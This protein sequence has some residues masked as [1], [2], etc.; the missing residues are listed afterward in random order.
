MKASCELD[1]PVVPEPLSDD[2]AVVA[3][4]VVVVDDVVVEDDPWTV[5]ATLAVFPLVAPVATMW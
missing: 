5:I 1:A 3:A 2:A 4:T